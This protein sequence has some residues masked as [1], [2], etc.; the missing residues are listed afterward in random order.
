MREKLTSALFGGSCFVCRG[1]ARALLCGEC[2]A[3]LPRLAG[4]LCPRCAL[5]SPGGLVCGRCLRRPP[6]YDATVA[7]LGYDF[8]ADVLVH[9]LKFRGELA[10]APLLAACLADRVGKVDC[11][12]P[13]PLSRERLKA[14][15]FNQSA[16]IARHVATGARLELALCERTRES[17]PQMELPYD[18]RQKNVRGAFRCTG[19]VIG[20]N[21]ALV[22][23][24]MTTGATL[25]ELARTLKQAGALSVTNWV[26]ARTL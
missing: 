12:I 5:R 24:V 9:A 11:V 3:E 26:V 6:A 23:D 25:D 14:R 7:A 1:A 19:N 4:P 8:P 16:E 2:D 13:V 17:P 20:A 10:L 22:D 21:V 18:A 15:G